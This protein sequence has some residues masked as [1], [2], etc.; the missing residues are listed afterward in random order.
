MKVRV[1]NFAKNELEG[2]EFLLKIEVRVMKVKYCL[3]RKYEE[4]AEV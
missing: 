3:Y 2:N 4:F 1:M